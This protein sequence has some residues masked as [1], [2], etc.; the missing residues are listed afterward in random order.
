MNALR[1]SRVNALRSSFSRKLRQ[2]LRRSGL[3]KTDATTECEKTKA[4]VGRRGRRLS[5]FILSGASTRNVEKRL[6]DVTQEIAD[7]TDPWKKKNPG[8]S[9]NLKKTRKEKGKL[10]LTAALATSAVMAQTAAKHVSRA[11][12]EEQYES[13]FHPNPASCSMIVL[14]E[15]SSFKCSTIL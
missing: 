15:F 13:I 3:G 2:S 4:S 9:L 12:R 11:L 7:Q 6:T 8:S 1:G 14:E 10:E 5:T